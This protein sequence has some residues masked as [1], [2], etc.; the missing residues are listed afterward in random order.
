MGICCMV[1]ETQTGALDQ[2]RSRGWGGRWKG[3]SKGEGIYVYLWLIHV[4][5]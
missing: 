1:Q 3:V 2:P 5:I 4:K